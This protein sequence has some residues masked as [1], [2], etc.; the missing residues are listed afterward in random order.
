[1]DGSQDP[2]VNSLGFRGSIGEEEEK[3]NSQGSAKRREDSFL[4]FLSTK[5]EI[6]KSLVKK[7]I[8]LEMRGGNTDRRPADKVFG[9]HSLL[10]TG[11]GP[12]TET[13]TYHIFA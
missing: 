10:S 6:R 7:E 4:F 5:T 3:G 9:F 12:H 8:K 1:M 13:E 2:K 11:M